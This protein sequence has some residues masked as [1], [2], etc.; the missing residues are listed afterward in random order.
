MPNH[1]ALN[2]WKQEIYSFIH[3][4]DKLKGNKRFPTSKQIYDW[5]YGKKEDVWTTKELVQ[6]MN[7]F[8]ENYSK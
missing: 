1:S 5:T 8:D 2:H 6:I 7:D 4:V 3:N